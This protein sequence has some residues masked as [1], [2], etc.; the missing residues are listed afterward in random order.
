MQTSKSSLLRKG[1]I[2]DA[3]GMATSFIPLI[4]PFLDIIWAPY[5]SKQMTEMYKG[6][7][8]K[9]A[10]VIVFIEEILPFTDVVPTFT[11]MW[12]YTFVWKKENTDDMQPIEVEVMD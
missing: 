8:G 6:K 9:I 1:I 10:S 11:L 7:D 4:G 3:I 5:A 12:F 2:F